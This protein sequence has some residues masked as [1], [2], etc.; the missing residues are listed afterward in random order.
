MN[1]QRLPPAANGHP[2]AFCEA[3][4]VPN[5]PV[6]DSLRQ[7][8]SLRVLQCHGIPCVLD[9]KIFEARR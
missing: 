8:N 2:P 7:H 5:K 4:L 1:G 3:P 6:R 9:K